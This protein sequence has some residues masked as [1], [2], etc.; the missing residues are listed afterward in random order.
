MNIISIGLRLGATIE[1]H[2][3]RVTSKLVKNGNMLRSFDFAHDRPPS[4]AFSPE[5]VEGSA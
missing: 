3:R 2:D 4:T 1:L 5:P